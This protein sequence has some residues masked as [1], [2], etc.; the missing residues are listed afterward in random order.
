MAS[1]SRPLPRPPRRC[2]ALLAGCGGSSKLSQEQLIK[3]A[4]PSVVRIEGNEGG[5][6]GLRDRC[7]TPA[8]PDQRPRGRGPEHRAEGAGRQRN[9]NHHAGSDRRRVPMRRPRRGETGEPRPAPESAEARHQREGH[10]GRT[11]DGDGLPGLASVRLRG[12]AGLHRRS[13]HGHRL[14]GEHPGQHELLGTQLRPRRS[15]PTRA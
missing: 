4:T 9:G 1:E 6:T 14:A 13:Q 15:R 2:A 10:A 7:R 3:Q 5:G 12:R 11:G 8:R